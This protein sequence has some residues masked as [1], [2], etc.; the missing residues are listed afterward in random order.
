MPVPLAVTDKVSVTVLFRQ[1]L[2]SD[3]E[4]CPVALT[5]V[6]AFTT[7]VATLELA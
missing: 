6:A 7:T 5:V 2:V 1:M 4:G 3:V